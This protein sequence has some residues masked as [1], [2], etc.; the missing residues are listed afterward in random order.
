MVLFKSKMHSRVVCTRRIGSGVWCVEGEA[1]YLPIGEIG[2]IM[3]GER[4]EWHP[5]REQFARYLEREV[6]LAVINIQKHGTSL[7]SSDRTNL[8]AR[9]LLKQTK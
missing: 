4:A 6:E 7:L 1:S 9:A 5:T 8:R 2:M 3:I